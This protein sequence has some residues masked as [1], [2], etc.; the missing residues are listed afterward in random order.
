MS[1]YDLKEIVIGP[2]HHGGLQ[3]AYGDLTKI[4]LRIVMIRNGGR[5]GMNAINFAKA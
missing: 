2:I 1:R 4:H 3:P 5:L